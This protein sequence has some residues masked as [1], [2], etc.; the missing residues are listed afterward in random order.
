MSLDTVRSSYTAATPVPPQTQGLPLIGSLPAFLRQPF[1]FLLAARQRHG[2]IYTLN[3]GFLR[4]VILNHPRHAEHVL[5]DNSQ[6][7]SKNGP[8]WEMVRTMLGNGLVVS[9][10]DFWLRQRRMIQPHFHRKQLAGLTEAMVSA[11]ADGLEGWEPAAATGKPFDLL[12]GFSSITMRVIARA[13]FGQGLAQADLDRVSEVMAFAMDY[14][15][16][17]SFTYSLPKWLPLPGARRYRAALQELD[18]LVA[19]IITNERNAETPS[20]SLL[21]MLVHMVDAESG[22]QMTD[23]QL[24]DEVKTFFLAGYETTSLAL[25]WAISLLNEHPEVLEKLRAEVDTVLGDRTPTFADLPALSYT[26][27]VIQETLRLRPASWW[28]PRTAVA[29]DTIDGYAIPAGT[30]V[31][32]L[33]YGIHHNPEVWDEPE[34]FDPERFSAERSASRHKSAW[35]PFGM[36]QRLCIGKDFSIMEAQLILAMIVQRYTFEPV[37]GPA[38]Q[39]K[40]SSTLK[41]DRSIE[42]VLKKRAG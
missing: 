13:L 15:M 17:A 26:K 18:E 1:A 3:L 19:K 35:V 21:A 20:N 11:T 40:I 8:L 41:P 6:N 37:P 29:D 12:P 14:L 27:M 10:G 31:V 39:P 22:E 42:V 25:T 23:K 16:T 2:D 33:T 4:W 28:L 36:G 9:E 5:R 7:Y 34:R 30:T 38:V 24:S 32:S